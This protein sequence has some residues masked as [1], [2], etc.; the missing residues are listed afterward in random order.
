MSLA[1]YAGRCATCAIFK[2]NKDPK[3]RD[4]RCM[5]LHRNR[6]GVV[7][8]SSSCKC[9]VLKPSTICKRCKTFVEHWYNFCPICA[10]PVN[11]QNIAMPQEVDKC[12]E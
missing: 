2:R 6:G 8:Y 1:N 11:Q 5:H 7:G 3:I 10:E 9:Y 4:G 12:G